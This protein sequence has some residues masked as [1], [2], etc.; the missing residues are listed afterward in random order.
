MRVTVTNVTD[1]IFK[2]THKVR[3]HHDDVCLSVNTNNN[4]HKQSRERDSSPPGFQKV[5]VDWSL[6]QRID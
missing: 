3:E 5:S 6:A 1:E 4:R 2:K